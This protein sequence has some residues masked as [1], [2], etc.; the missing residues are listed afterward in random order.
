LK[1]LIH[2]RAN[3]PRHLP[4]AETVKKHIKLLHEYND[5]R[6]VGQ[7]LIGM[8]A[9]N[10]GVRIGGRSYFYTIHTKES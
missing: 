6:D 4:A 10:R 8:I 7:G 1:E 3:C 5:I 2:I 9:E